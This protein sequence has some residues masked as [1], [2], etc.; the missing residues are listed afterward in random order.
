MNDQNTSNDS[1]SGANDPGNLTLAKFEAFVNNLM[2]DDETQRKAILSLGTLISDKPSISPQVA[3]MARIQMQAALINAKPELAV[4]V[5]QLNE[6]AIELTYI[7]E[8]RRAYGDAMVN[9]ALDDART[10]YRTFYHSM[11]LRIMAQRLNNDFDHLRNVFAQLGKALGETLARGFADVPYEGKGAN[12][13]ERRSAKYG[14]R[15]KKEGDQQWARRNNR[16]RRR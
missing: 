12:R 8:M 14:T 5:T 3:M 10:S 15:R 9:G 1:T 4:Y 6:D 16:K 7:E 2:P 13:E 11:Q